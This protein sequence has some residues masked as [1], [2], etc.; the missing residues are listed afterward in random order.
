MAPL[1]N[2]FFCAITYMIAREKQRKQLG[3]GAIKDGETDAKNVDSPLG[4]MLFR[5]LPP[6]STTS[7]KNSVHGGKIHYPAGSLRDTDD[8]AGCPA[9]IK[10]L[11]SPFF[12]HFITFCL[13]SFSCFQL[14]DCPSMRWVHSIKSYEVRQVVSSTVKLLK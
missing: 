11:L 1:P 13:R 4:G 8:D 5:S 12:V 3:S 6:S 10:N 14:R 9:D 2:C 7:T